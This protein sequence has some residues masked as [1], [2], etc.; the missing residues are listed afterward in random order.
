MELTLETPGKNVPPLSNHISVSKP[1]S[2]K[3]GSFAINSGISIFCLI[4]DISICHPSRIE[5]IILTGKKNNS[6]N[7]SIAIIIQYCSDLSWYEWY[8]IA[9]IQLKRGFRYSS[10]SHFTQHWP[11]LSLFCSVHQSHSIKYVQSIGKCWK[12]SPLKYS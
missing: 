12:P 3:F 9:S 2:C 11:V 5:N 10:K 8:L 7:I 1:F 4:S 6:K